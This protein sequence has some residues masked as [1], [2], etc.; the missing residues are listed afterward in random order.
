MCNQHNFFLDSDTIEDILSLFKAFVYLEQQFSDSFSQAFEKELLALQSPDIVIEQ[1][2][3]KIECEMDTQVLF[4]FN[5]LCN[6]E[7]T[8]PI[9]TKFQ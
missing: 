5:L 4:K 6:I 3:R 2:L 8:S 1:L 7:S 9:K